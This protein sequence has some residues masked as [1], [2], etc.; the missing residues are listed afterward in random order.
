MSSVKSVKRW[1]LVHKWTSLICTV[2]LLMLCVTGLPLI[3]HEEFESLEAPLAKGASSSGARASLDRIVENGLEANPDK[4]I[5]FLFWDEHQPNTVS[6]S[7]SDSVDAPPTNFKIVVMDEYT[8]Q[9]LDEPN[10]QEGFMYTMLQLHTDMFMGI[11][12]KLFLGL[13]G[14]LFVA[15]IVSGI[16]LYGPIM[17]KYDFGMIRTQRSKRLKWLDMHNL[18]GIVTISW[19]SVVGLTGVVNTLSDVVLALWQQGQLAE[20]VAPYQNAEPL[21]GQ[22]SSL[23]GAFETAREADVSME[24]YLAAFP[25]TAFSSRHHY[26]IFV[27]GKTPLTERLVR[28]ALIDAKS[29][30]LTDMREMPWFV[31]ALFLSQPLH[32]GDYGG[33][34][35]KILWAL[36]DIVTIIVLISGLYLWFARNKALK[37]QM[38][39]IVQAAGDASQAANESEILTLKN[40]ED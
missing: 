4:V 12:G 29:G 10:V 21:E 26:A 7:L 24:P 13:M 35:L 15:A 9:V 34:T 3:F 27:K 30:N 37:K 31:N 23:D 22:L 25:G 20:M 1:F 28:P 19:A 11:G 8:A 2:F 5:R 38:T 6:L 18:L 32:F 16:F 33:M 36:F 14:M 40:E 17:K 39:R